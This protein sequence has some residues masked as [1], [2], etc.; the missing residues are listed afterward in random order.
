ML[1]FDI[2][3][4]VDSK[5]FWYIYEDNV[6]FENYVEL[7][8]SLGSGNVFFGMGNYYRRELEVVVKL[9]RWVIMFGDFMGVSVVFMFF[10]L[11]IVVIV[12]CL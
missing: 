5:R 10:L 2:L 7:F 3:F 9:Y 1:I 6:E 8:I 4:V 11:V 12:F